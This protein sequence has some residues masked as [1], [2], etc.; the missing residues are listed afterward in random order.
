MTDSADV[1]ALLDQVEIPRTVLHF[2]IQHGAGDAVVLQYQPLVDAAPRVAQHQILAAFAADEIADRIQIDAGDLEPRRRGLLH[3]APV[4]RAGQ[5]GAANARLL[6]DRSDQSKSGA[7]VLHAFADG[8]DTRI[9]GLQR[10]VD[11]DGA[12]AVQAGALR[13]RDVGPHAG[14]HHHQVGRDLAAVL[15]A[16]GANILGADDFG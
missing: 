8:V 5:M 6:P 12:L 3:I 14:S 10:V 2:A 16:H 1:G 7:A 11:D 9:V 13:Q 4:S 15:E